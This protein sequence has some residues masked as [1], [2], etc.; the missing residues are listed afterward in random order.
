MHLQI[1]RGLLL[2]AVASR[3]GRMPVH[4]C[5][6]L[7]ALALTG[8]G[9]LALSDQLGETKLYKTCTSIYTHTQTSF[10]IG[11]PVLNK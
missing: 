8:R 5:W 4:V 2:L 9:L 10:L 1:C 7:L 3:G 11:Q 6:D